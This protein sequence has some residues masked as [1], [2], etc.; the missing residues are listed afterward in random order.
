MGKGQS[1]QQVVL[2]KLDI[3]TQNNRYLTPY[4]KVNSIWTEKIINLRPKPIK[5]P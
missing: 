5:R 1:L 3:H 2:G 4:T